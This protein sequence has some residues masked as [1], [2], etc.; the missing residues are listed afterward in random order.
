MVVW[1]DDVTRFYGNISAQGGAQSGNG[2]NVEVSGKSHLDFNGVA[3]T[4]A[5]NGNSGTLLLDPDSIDIVA[6]TGSN[7]NITS[8]ATFTAVG[9][10][11]STLKVGTLTTQLGLGSVTVD[12][13]GPGGF[14]DG[15]I[16]VSTPV[17][18]T[19]GNTL[20]FKTPGTG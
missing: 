8:G 15:A 2:G 6:D 7:T 5:S 9:T 1:A 12:A 3:D 10:G 20:T 19:S 16:T 14:T 13:T 18:Y 4:R 11:A 17:T